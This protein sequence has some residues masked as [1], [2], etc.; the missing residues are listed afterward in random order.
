[1]RREKQE[2]IR[3]NK[4]REKKMMRR[5]DKN[6]LRFDMIIFSFARHTTATQE[7][8]CKILQSFAIRV[9]ISFKV[10]ETYS[11]S[12][13]TLYHYRYQLQFCC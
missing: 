12:I 11:P 4:R 10:N 8:T 13:H 1:M 6:I 5:K 7:A 3:E 9:K 2:I